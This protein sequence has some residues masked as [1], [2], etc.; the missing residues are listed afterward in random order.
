MAVQA[1]LSSPMARHLLPRPAFVQGDVQGLGVNDLAVVRETTEDRILKVGHFL[2]GLIRPLELACSQPDPDS[3]APQPGCTT[4][5][6]STVKTLKDLRGSEP[7]SAIARN[8]APRKE[9]PKVVSRSTP[10]WQCY[11]LTDKHHKS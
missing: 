4:L 2:V 5:P 6:S 3:G 1:T 11:S 8:T 9:A 7:L 10:L